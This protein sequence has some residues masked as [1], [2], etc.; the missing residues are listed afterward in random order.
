MTALKCILCGDIKKHIELRED[1]L[2]T[3][4]QMREIVMKWAVPTRIEKKEGTLH[5]WMLTKLTRKIHLKKR[6]EVM[7]QDIMDGEEDGME[8]QMWIG[9]EKEEKEATAKDIGPTSL[10]VEMG[11]EKGK[12]E[13]VKEISMECH[14]GAKEEKEKE[15]PWMKRY[16]TNVVRRDTLHTNALKE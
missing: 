16:A 14:T 3:Y 15:N 7:K 8:K 10:V 5:P 11:K 12:M 1:D 9:L 4:E 13:E 6:M 2:K